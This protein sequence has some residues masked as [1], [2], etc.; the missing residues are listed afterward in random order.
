MLK[1]DSH[2]GS[3]IMRRASCTIR[4][5]RVGMPNGLF[6]SLF[7]FGM[8][9][10]RTGIGSKVLA[11]SAIWRREIYPSKSPRK[12][13][14]VIVSTPA[15]LLPVFLRVLLAATRSHTALQSSP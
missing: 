4:S 1:S 14:L 11:L 9:T 5:N 10:L 8:Y 13:D 3:R 15:V 12:F 7:G 6:F 2:T